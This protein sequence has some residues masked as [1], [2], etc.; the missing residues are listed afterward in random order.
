[1]K[2]FLAL[3]LATA[4]TLAGAGE[5]AWQAPQ[6]LRQAA[7]AL[8][9]EQLAAPGESLVVTAAIDDQLRLPACAAPVAARVQQQRGSA[10][11]AALS[12]TEPSPWTI[13]VV[14]AVS[15]QAEVLVLNR[16]LTAGETVTAEMVA[17]RRREVSELPYG[18][19]SALE[20]AVGQTARRALPA[21][22]VIAPADLAPAR[23]VRR[24]QPVTLVSRA[25]ILRVRAPGQAM[26]DGAAG[27]YIQV[28]NLNSRRMVR[29]R[30]R[31]GQEV[32]V[33]S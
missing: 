21:G 10:L 18:F 20:V 33:D 6:G 14:V 5:G 3:L 7:E 1:M 28:Q 32:E 15:R 30:V 11:T 25:G 17:R 19:L 29:G 2:K 4:A 9:R 12:C 13:Y 23:L 24:G 22:A 26:S 27:D 16:A 31:S 8:A